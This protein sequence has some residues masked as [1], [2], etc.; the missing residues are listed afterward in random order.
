[1]SQDSPALSRSRLTR[2]LGLPEDASRRL[3]EQTAPRLLTSL[4]RRLDRADEASATALRKEIADLETSSAYFCA[5][6]VAPIVGPRL[7]DRRALRAVLFGALLV[8]LLLLVAGLAGLRIIRLESGPEDIAVSMPAQL[9]LEGALPRATLRVF[10]A[11]R[12]ELFVKTAAHGARV[13]LDA[14][15]YTLD[16]RREDCPDAWTH[17]VEFEEGETRR[18]EPLLCVGQGR[19]T[20][21]SNVSSDRLRIDGLELGETTA[22]AH[23]LTVGDHEVRIDKPGFEPFVGRVRIRPDEAL[24]IRAELVAVSGNPPPRGRP[25]PVTKRPPSQAPET[26]VAPL[27]FDRPNFLDDPE[28]PL[29]ELPTIRGLPG[30]DG[31]RSPGGS[32]PWHDSVSAELV[33][34]YDLDGSGQIDGLPESEAIPCEVWRRIEREFDEGGLGLSMVRY[35]GFDGSEWHPN[36]LGF[37]RAHRS[38][39]FAKMKECGLRG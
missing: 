20:V 6:P 27:P 4:N 3:I 16:V 24:E 15:L 18:F 30:G 36:A 9:V 38:A 34:R 1:M 11:D 35:Y 31:T 7:I 8:F 28:N 37:T 26:A 39:V 17:S 22:K 23:P 25:I 32:T 29:L 5:L 14:G 13:E 21:R 10:D 19:L 33:A 12:E 2:V